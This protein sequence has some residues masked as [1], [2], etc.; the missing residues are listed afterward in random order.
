M[1]FSAYGMLSG[2][3]VRGK[4]LGLELALSGWKMVKSI[5]LWVIVDFCL[6]IILLEE[7]G[8]ILMGIKNGGMHQH[9]KMDR[10]LCNN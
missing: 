8:T 5:D 7:I 4:L 10:L 9:H 6:L 1:I 3:N 2:W